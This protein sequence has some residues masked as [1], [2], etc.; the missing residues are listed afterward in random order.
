VYVYQSSYCLD[1]SIE[2]VAELF[3][4]TSLY[5]RVFA[6]HLAL[7]LAK[8]YPLER[9]RNV[10]GELLSKV[11]ALLYAKI[12]A[13]HLMVARGLFQ[14]AFNERIDYLSRRY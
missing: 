2:Y 7:F 8:I 4:S 1:T 11:D 9:T 6:F 14:G 5:R 13:E 10:L 3:A 12:S